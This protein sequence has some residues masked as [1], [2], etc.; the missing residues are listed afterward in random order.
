MI[1]E[2]YLNP[3]KCV[4]RTS[5]KKP[6]VEVACFPPSVRPVWFL[7]CSTVQGSLLCLWPLVRL[8]SKPVFW[9]HSM[10]RTFFQRILQ[11]L[12]ILWKIHTVSGRVQGG[13]QVEGDEPAEEQLGV[14]DPHPLHIWNYSSKKEKQ[15]VIFIQ[16]FSMCR[17]IIHVWK[18]R[19][20]CH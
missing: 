6:A 4:L 5:A 14:V 12:C 10:K 16:S 8:P 11:F 7:I 9:R 18:A 13:G 17:R 2:F 3:E 19:E 20:L 1:L 15:N